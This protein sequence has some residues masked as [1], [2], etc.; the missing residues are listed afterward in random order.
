MDAGCVG[1]VA[2]AH[3]RALKDACVS[4]TPMVS[5][6]TQAP[7]RSEWYDA[8]PPRPVRRHS[9]GVI[10]GRRVPDSTSRN[11]R[12]MATWDACLS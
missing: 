4:H 12:I 5:M 3:P 9:P 11:A 6:G 1:V 2:G 8:S 7:E 10:Y